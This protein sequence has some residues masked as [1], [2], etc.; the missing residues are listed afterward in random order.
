[1]RCRALHVLG[2]AP[3]LS[4]FHFS[5]LH[6]VAWYCAPGGVR[7]VPTERILAAVSLV[8]KA[9]LAHLCVMRE[10]DRRDSNPRP[11]EPQS[12]DI[13]FWALPGVAESAYLSELLCSGLHVDSAYCAL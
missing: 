4:R 6:S 2:N 11:S 8:D 5:G 10:G 12:A 7:V 9:Y 13:S 3:Y 1:M